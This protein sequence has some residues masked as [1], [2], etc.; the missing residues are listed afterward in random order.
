MPCTPRQA[1]VGFQ[2]KRLL[3]KTRVHDHASET[4]GAHLLLMLLGGERLLGHLRGFMRHLRVTS[5]Q[6]AQC[7]RSEMRCKQTAPAGGSQCAHS[8]GKRSVTCSKDPAFDLQSITPFLEHSKG[9]EPLSPSG[10]LE[11]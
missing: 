3:C 7:W 11:F 5:L 2:R 4:P 10:Y 6:K 8:K 1:M 9:K